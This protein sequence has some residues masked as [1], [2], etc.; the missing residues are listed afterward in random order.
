MEVSVIILIRWNYYSFAGINNNFLDLQ[1]YYN[2]LLG[3]W[4]AKYEKCPRKG[5]VR[6]IAVHAV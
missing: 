6:I 5:T 3:E 1:K 4:A 2:I